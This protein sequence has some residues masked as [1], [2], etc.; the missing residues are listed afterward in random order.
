[1]KLTEFFQLPEVASFL[2]A[3]SNID[4]VDQWNRAIAEI[5]S[6]LRKQDPHLLQDIYNQFDSFGC[7]DHSPEGALRG[8]VEEQC[9]VMH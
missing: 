5:R 7:E 6:Y 4:K 2:K 3:A 1:M 9:V 8:W